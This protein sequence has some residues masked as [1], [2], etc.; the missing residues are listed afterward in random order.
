MWMGVGLRMGIGTQRP[1]ESG[2][3]ATLRGAALRIDGT[4][5]EPR[6]AAYPLG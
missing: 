1:Y 3:P 5:L 6:G 4:P 2:A